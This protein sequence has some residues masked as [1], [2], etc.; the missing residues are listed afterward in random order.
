MDVGMTMLRVPESDVC[1]DCLEN[2]MSSFLY[3]TKHF[4]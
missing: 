4:E 1:I 2:K 3:K